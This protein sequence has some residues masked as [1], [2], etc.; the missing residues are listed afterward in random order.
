MVIMPFCARF[1]YLHGQIGYGAFLWVGV[2]GSNL[3]GDLTKL[4]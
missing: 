3:H 4:D 2:C 1:S